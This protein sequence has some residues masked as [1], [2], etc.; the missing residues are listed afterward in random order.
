MELPEFSPRFSQFIRGYLLEDLDFATVN[1][2]D[3]IVPTLARIAVYG[4][5]A[6][7]DGTGDRNLIG[8]YA[9]NWQRVGQAVVANFREDRDGVCKAMVIASKEGDLLIADEIGCEPTSLYIGDIV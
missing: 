3:E 1:D 2:D 9:L 7:Y 6:K 4:L 8:S 5:M